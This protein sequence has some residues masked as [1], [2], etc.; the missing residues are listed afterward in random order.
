[1][2]FLIFLLYLFIFAIFLYYIGKLYQ[3]FAIFCKRITYLFHNEYNFYSTHLS[4]QKN[5][6]HLV[7]HIF[8]L[9]NVYFQLQFTCILLILLFFFRCCLQSIN[10]NGQINLFVGTH[11]EMIVFFNIMFY[12]F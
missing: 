3:Y 2:P 10:M 5:A 9:L 8:I 6:M 4:I 11:C 12:F 1:M 7:H